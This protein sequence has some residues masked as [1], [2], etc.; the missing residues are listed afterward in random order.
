MD[1][2]S[3]WLIH[4]DQP[5]ILE[6]NVQGDVFGHRVV[7]LGWWDAET[8]SLPSV[9]PDAWPNNTTVQFGPLVLD[10]FTNLRATVSITTLRQEQINPL[11]FSRFW[12]NEIAINILVERVIVIG[13]GRLD[14]VTG[15]RNERD[16]G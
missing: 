15:V 6:Q 9:D 12:D 13:R 1:N 3:G 8:D 14:L 7:T 11:A 16:P 10:C 5:V 2:H 4:N